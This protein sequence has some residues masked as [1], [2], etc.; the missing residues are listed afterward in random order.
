MQDNSL[1]KTTAFFMLGAA[2]G[3]ALTA[4]ATPRN[5]PEMRN[6]IVNKLRKTREK[7]NDSINSFNEISDDMASK[8][9]DKVK[10]LKESEEI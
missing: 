5:G 10:N 2:A 9:D 1:S 3:A 8:L 4:I 6:E 7:T